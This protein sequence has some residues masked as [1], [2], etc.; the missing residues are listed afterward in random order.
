MLTHD[1]IDTVALLKQVE[2]P[3]AGAV[4][5]FLGVTREFTG[6]RQTAALNYECYP[7]M[8]ERKIAELEA[9]ARRRW[10]IVGCA[11]VHRLGRLELTEA[12][13]AIAVSS[14]HRAD[15]FAAGQWLIDTLKEVVPIWKQELWADG[16]SEWVHPGTAG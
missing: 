1:P 14:P 8:A 9:E 10:P 4:V 6:E 13:V 12:S 5:L 15:A 11:I 2:S 16:T 3:R 7:E